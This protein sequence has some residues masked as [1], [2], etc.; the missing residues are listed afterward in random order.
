M[1]IM[2]MPVL[3]EA[4]LIDK[5][6][7]EL[8]D[9]ILAEQRA[10]DRRNT[11]GEAGLE[12]QLTEA[13]EAADEAMFAVIECSRKIAETPFASAAGAELKVLALAHH[14]GNFDTSDLPKPGEPLEGKLEFLLLGSVAA[15]L[16]MTSNLAT[17]AAI[18]EVRQLPAV[19]ASDEWSD[20]DHQL[21]SAI[22][23]EIALDRGDFDTKPFD[24]ETPE[25]SEMHSARSEAICKRTW[26]TFYRLCAMDAAS[27]RGLEL[28]A[29]ALAYVECHFY[30]KCE[31]DDRE[32]ARTG[33]HRMLRSMGADL[34]RHSDTQL[35]AVIR[36]A[37][38]PSPP[39]EPA[40]G[41]RPTSEAAIIADLDQRFASTLAEF[42]HQ[43]DLAAST[44]CTEYTHEQDAIADAAYAAHWN[45]LDDIAAQPLTTI[46]GLLLKGLALAHE[47]T[48]D[49]TG[50]FQ[51]DDLAV[52]FLL[53]AVNVLPFLSVEPA[54]IALKHRLSKRAEDAALIHKLDIELA[55]VCIRFAQE[56]ADVCHRED[57]LAAL[58]KEGAAPE[59]IRH[60]EWCISSSEGTARD[61]LNMPPQILKT[62]EETY[63]H[64][65]RAEGF[66]QIA[67]AAYFLR[68][69]D[70]ELKSIFGY[71]GQMDD[72]QRGKADIAIDR[73]AK[74]PDF[75]VSRLIMAGDECTWVDTDNIADGV[76]QIEYVL[77]GTNT[78]AT[79]GRRAYKGADADLLRLAGCLEAIYQL[80]LQ[81]R[82]VGSDLVDCPFYEIDWQYRE[83]IN[84]IQAKT[85]A[86]IKAKGRAAEIALF[87]EPDR[88]TDGA[89]TWREITESIET[90]MRAI[91]ARKKGTTRKAA[92]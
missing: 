53:D 43:D 71:L 72:K 59:K 5:L 31:G 1:N 48:E 8:A 81:Y 3:S 11:A 45:V 79:A 51:A 38:P 57:K 21:A 61:V 47:M 39:H 77:F 19:V 42:Q 17:A 89:G 44:P 33:P 84:A 27:P 66:K 70:G 55:A 56:N 63:A 52:S 87:T 86:G 50:H 2:T 12:P 9:A 13:E 65:M 15:D 80:R 26:D 54:Q 82:A 83:R 58:R 60:A 68:Q 34:L 64:S 10:Y 6:D 73:L 78:L 85:M 37:Q 20:I 23:D 14:T 29:L 28:K 74:Y 30:P 22:S 91:N 46:N 35:A 49:P 75:A 4:A 24:Q 7:H 18:R 16:L 69:M 92:A 36:Q 90:D 41:D 88:D 32:T 62:I 76:E 25:E 40:Q 67:G